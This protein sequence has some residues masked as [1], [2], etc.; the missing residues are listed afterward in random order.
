MKNS[1]TTADKVC[2]SLQCHVA[3]V[4]KTSQGV[5]LPFWRLCSCVLLKELHDYQKVTPSPVRPVEQLDLQE[6]RTLKELVTGS[7]AFE[8]VCSKTRITRF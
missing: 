2:K 1:S 6:L 4:I 7:A 5:W 3:R 8:A